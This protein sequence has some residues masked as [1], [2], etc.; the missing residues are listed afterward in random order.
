[1]LVLSKRF[2]GPNNGLQQE[3]IERLAEI[4]VAARRSRLLQKIRPSAGN[5]DHQAIMR[6]R[7]RLD[8]SRGFEPF[9]VRHAQIHE[10]GQW[11]MPQSRTHAVL[12]VRFG[13]RAVS[14]VSQASRPNDSG[15]G[16]VVDDEHEW[17]VL[18]EAAL[19]TWRAQSVGGMARKVCGWSAHA[20]ALASKRLARRGRFVPG[21]AIARKIRPKSAPRG[22]GLAECAGC[23]GTLAT[24]GRSTEEFCQPTRNGS[25]RSRRRSLG[26]RILGVAM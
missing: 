6:L 16:I 14:E 17:L 7:E 5:D 15:V 1:V 9:Q 20:N 19:Q 24:L 25:A 8:A 4:R 11:S 12:G 22:C 13:G 3:R 23:M 26:R 2:R 10:N 21:P 18:T